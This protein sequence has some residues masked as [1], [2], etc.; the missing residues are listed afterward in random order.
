VGPLEI[1]AVKVT[2]PPYVIGELEVATVSVGT[3]AF[4]CMT[5]VLVALPAL[6]VIVTA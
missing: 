4:N 6:A 1:V 5:K 2:V 3:D